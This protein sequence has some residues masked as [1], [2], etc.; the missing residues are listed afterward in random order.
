MTDSTHRPNPVLGFYQ[1]RP[2]RLVVTE[3]GSGADINCYRTDARGND[4]LLFGGTVTR[5]TRLADGWSGFGLQ[6]VRTDSNSC[7]S[8]GVAHE[9]SIA[10]PSS[11]AYQWVDRFE[12]LQ[13]RAARPL[14][15]GNVTG[16]SLAQGWFGDEQGLDTA[17]VYSRS[18]LYYDGLVGEEAVFGLDIGGVSTE[19]PGF[20]LRQHPPRTREQH[21]SVDITRENQQTSIRC[22]M[23]LL[24]RF[25]AQAFPSGLIDT[26]GRFPASPTVR[27]GY[28][29][30]GYAVYVVHD[31]SATPVW[32]LEVRHFRGTT[33]QQY[34]G[35]LLATADLTALGLSVGTSFNLD[36][37][38]RNFDGNSY[39]VGTF[40]SI[41]VE[42]NSTAITP[43]AEDLNGIIEIDDELI[44]FRSAATQDA[45]GVGLYMI[46][47]SL[48][49]AALVAADNFT[50]EALTVPPLTDPSEQLSVSIP[51]E[52]DGKSG[53]LPGTLDARINEDRDGAA[54]AFD[55]E[56]GLRSTAAFQPA[57]RRS[58]R[59]Q[60]TFEEAD[61]AA[62]IALFEANGTQTPFDWTHP[63]TSEALVV[64]FDQEEIEFRDERLL[65]GSVVYSTS[66]TLVEAFS[67]T[68]FNS[69]L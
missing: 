60:A 34:Q 4:R 35:T 48:G 13:R 68:V 63:Y 66:L 2:L 33:N 9:F 42:I 18:T 56:S 47:D 54:R 19:W 7:T 44:D 69:E 40:V 22:E 49:L 46:P 16:T 41:A 12:R 50:E 25:T 3:D 29:K 6:T 45:G 32:Q 30:E 55:T 57:S 62:L 31:T 23:G 51:A 59:V 39:G 5:G 58:W 52:A 21:F 36:A 64:F 67:S 38:I 17:Q 26:R 61:W 10:D 8:V 28:Y 20:H 65:N 11:G 53:A 15:D 14:T 1:P 37:E 43:V 24:L 27:A